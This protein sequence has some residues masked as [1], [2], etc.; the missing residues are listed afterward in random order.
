MLRA[1]FAGCLAVI[2]LA[3]GQAYAQAASGPMVDASLVSD[4]ISVAPGETFHLALHQEITPHWHTYWRNPGDSGEATRLYLDLPEGWSEGE[5]VWPAPRTYPLGPLT[6]YGYENSVTLPVPVTVP[7]DAAPGPVTIT[8]EGTWLVCEDIC[9]P[10][11]ATF[12]IELEVG[13]STVDPSGARLI[14]AAYAA[15]PDGDH[16]FTAGLELRDG[17][18]VLTLAGDALAGGEASVRDL[19]FFPY[20]GGVIAHNAPQPYRLGEGEARM[21]IATGF[22]TRNAV[23]A[24]YAG[25]LAYE[26]RENGNWVRRTAEITAIA[27]ESLNALPAPAAAPASSLDDG[28]GRAAP[29]MGFWQAALLALVGGLI[30]NLMP[31]VFPILS[32]KA[33]TIVQKRGAERSEARELGL[34]FGAGVVLTFLALGGVVLALRALGGMEVWGFQLQEPVVVAGLAALM[35]LIGLN[36]LGFFEIGTSLQGVG[37]QVQGND[38]AGAFLTGVLAVFVAAP[39]LAPVMASALAFALAQPPLA[40]LTIF[41]FLGVGLALPFVIV[42]F[43]PRL[44]AFLPRPGAWM[45]RFKQFLAFPMFATAI[46]LIWVLSVQTGAQ[47]VLWV[48]GLFLAIGFAVWAFRMPG[49]VSRVAGLAGVLLA[50]GALWSTAGLEPATAS[51]GNEEYENWSPERVEALRSEGRAVFVDFTAA[52]CVTCQVNKLGALADGDVRDAF[53]RNDVAL[54]RADFTNRDPVIAQV[55][56]D[57]GAPGVPFYLMYP[58]GGGEPE[59][60]PPLLTEAIMI[61]AVETAVRE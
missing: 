10:E 29:A 53:A 13:A 1:F 26:Q 38:R 16:G 17:G 25:V 55:L 27:N 6:N 14:E 5:M 32:M 11:D 61:R 7:A 19:Y 52:W 46:W 8:G 35:F 15:A 56:A 54:L 9:I 31:C 45:E 21:D 60:L 23:N 4:R 33:L 36:F 48:L 59:I 18:L 49:L 41:A 30:L 37:G 12:E 50:A 58:Q 43:E 39:C 51:A 24:D 34:I 3:S 22:L 42:S 28:T 2:A 47:G 44:L 20:D 57:Y 40:S